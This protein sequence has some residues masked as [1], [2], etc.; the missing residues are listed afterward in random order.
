[1]LLGIIKDITKNIEYYINSEKKD[2]VY[3]ISFTMV[4]NDNIKALSKEEIRS[5]LKTILSSNLTYKEKWNDYDVYLDEANN[6]RYFKNGRENFFMFL[7]N[8]GVSAIN[9]FNKISKTSKSK[10]YNIIAANIAFSLILSSMALIPFAGDIQIR[11]RLDTTVSSFINLSADELIDSIQSSKYLTD[12][13]KEFLCNED[14]FNFVIENSDP[15][16]NYSLR[17]AFDEVKIE[18][19]TEN[20]V[21]NA[22][23]YF[24]PL[25]PNTIYILESNMNNGDVNELIIH[26]FIHLIQSSSTPSYIKEA[27]VEMFKSEWY[28]KP[29]IAY[30]ECVKRTKVLMEIIGPGPIIDVNFKSDNKSFINAL[31]EYLSPEE[32]EN[33]L[34][35]LN[36]ASTDIVDPNFDMNSVNSSIDSYLAKMYYNKTGKNIED[37]NMIKQIYTNGAPTRFYFNT[38]RESYNKDYLLSSEKVLMEM[39]SVTEITSSDAVENYTYYPIVD[40]DNS[41]DSTSF[42]VTTDFSAIPLEKTYTINIKFKDG[43]VGYMYFDQEKEQWSDVEHY[44]FVRQYEPAIPKKFPDQVKESINV[45]IIPEKVESEAKSI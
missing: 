17:K 36:T 2:N 3:E 15:I 25:H 13:E 42:E 44:K 29:N 30:Q 45:K 9:Y 33:L 43:T 40:K 8:N 21:K 14:F 35:L 37:D 12:E 38:K 39:V 5:L 24:D 34:A 19:F 20:E 23:G 6:K 26:E 18:T 10:S 27:S 32:T 1:M 7:E 28:G 4:T 16:R 11:E 41:K 22:D 31:S